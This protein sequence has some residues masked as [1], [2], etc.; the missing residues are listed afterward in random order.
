[1]V[2]HGARVVRSRF[3]ECSQPRLSLRRTTTRNH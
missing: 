3:S 1:M 2:S